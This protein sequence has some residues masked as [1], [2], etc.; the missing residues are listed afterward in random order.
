MAGPAGQ[1]TREGRGLTRRRVV[2]LRRTA[3]ALCPGR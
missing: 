3:A 1:L 2:D